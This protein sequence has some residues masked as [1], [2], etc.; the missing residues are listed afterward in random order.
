M[1]NRTTYANA[2]AL[3]TIVPTTTT[4][5]NM[6]FIAYIVCDNMNAVN[7]SFDL[8]GQIYECASYD[9]LDVMLA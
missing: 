2:N 5:F 9:V 6:F 1:A 8:L 4:L 7:I 3:A